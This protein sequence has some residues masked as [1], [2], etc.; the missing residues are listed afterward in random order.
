MPQVRRKAQGNVRRAPDCALQVVRERRLSGG[1]AGDGGP[2]KDEEVRRVWVFASERQRE[3]LLRDVHAGMMDLYFDGAC[4]PWN[5]GGI[6]S[7]GFV[8]LRGG[9][10]LLEGKGVVGTP[11]TPDS[12]N[13]VA[14]YAGMTRGLEAAAGILEPREDVKVKGDSQ[15]ALYQVAGKYAVNAERLKAPHADA[16]GR[17]ADLRAKGHPLEL[18]WIPREENIHADR[19]SNEAIDEHLAKNPGALDEVAL[20]FGKHKG[21]KW[22]DVPK[23]YRDWLLSKR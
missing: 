1:G 7:Y 5:P 21:T 18:V 17:V 8:L 4:R 3:S 9:K 10:V 23:G 2:S 20:G 6:A 14:E 12:T 15:L 11:G 16:S 22:R 13:N 19:L